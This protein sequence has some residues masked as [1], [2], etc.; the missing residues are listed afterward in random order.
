MLTLGA[1]RP[2]FD[3]NMQPQSLFAVS[4]RREVT[5]VDDKASRRAGW[6]AVLGADGLP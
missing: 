3:T 4:A 5:A 6:P 1:D 2:F